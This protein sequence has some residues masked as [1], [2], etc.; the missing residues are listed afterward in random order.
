[1]TELGITEKRYRQIMGRFNHAHK[2]DFGCPIFGFHTSYA[3]YYCKCGDSH[4]IGEDT[5]MTIEEAN[6]RAEADWS[7]TTTEEVLGE[8]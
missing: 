2:W 8:F 6:D 4:A 1:M 3:T 7:A 5:E